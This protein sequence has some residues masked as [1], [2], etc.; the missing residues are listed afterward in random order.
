LKKLL[1]I[2]AIINLT[3]CAEKSRFDCPYGKG[4]SCISM[5]EIDKNIK[6]NAVAP[7]CN[8]AS[9][10]SKA[11]SSA[12]SKVKPPITADAAPATRIPEVVLQMW[13][14]PYEANNGIYYQASFVNIIVRDASWA[15]PVLDD[16][17]TKEAYNG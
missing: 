2:I 3:G 17:A 1:I 6:N 12:K 13:V 5:S 9:C 7:S 8:T 16:A 4:P 15:A 14:S 10:G 11:I